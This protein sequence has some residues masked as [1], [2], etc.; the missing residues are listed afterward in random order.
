MVTKTNTIAPAKI[1]LGLAVTGIR[2][3]GYHLLETVFQ[4]ISL[5]DQI[6]V[7][8]TGT[9]IECDC[10]ELSGKDN[11]AY[12]AASLFLD[13]LKDKQGISENLGIKIVIEKN[14]PVQA[15]LAGGSTDAAA[16]IR[17]LNKLFNYPFSSEQLLDIA[18]KIGSDTAY[19]LEGGTKWGEGTGSTLSPL[20]QAPEMNLILVKPPQGV[21]TAE[22]YRLFDKTGKFSKLDKEQWIRALQKGDI[23][24]IA[25]IMNNSLEGPAFYL[26]PE[27]KTIKEILLENGCLGALMSGSGSA[28]FGI[29]PD[30]N[31]GIKIKARLSAE[32][33]S[34]SWLVKTI[35]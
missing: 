35:V 6:E 23:D 1:N 30:K 19:C 33:L 4:T 16:V 34:S 20:P 5:Y 10:G 2:D 7:E 22:A 27:I 12:K 17:C 28:V 15:G 9:G 25:E 18:S 29:L 31:S 14:I 3:D 8:I 21:S 11:L 13:E 26:V 32:G 24:L